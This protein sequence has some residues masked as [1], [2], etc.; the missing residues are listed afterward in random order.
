MGKI[1]FL[2]FEFRERDYRASDLCLIVWALLLARK[3]YFVCKD[4]FFYAF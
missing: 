4:S 1:L 2:T 3:D